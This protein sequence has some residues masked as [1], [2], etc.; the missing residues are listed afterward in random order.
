MSTVYTFIHLYL[1]RYLFVFFFASAAVPSTAQVKIMCL[2][3][4]ITQGNTENPGYRY[5]LWQKLIDAGVDVQ[6]VGSHAVNEGG[7]S[8]VEGTV[9]KGVPYINRNEGHWGWTVDEILSGRDGKGHLSRWLQSYTPDIA[10]IHLGTNDM[11]RQCGTGNTCYQETIDELK[12]VVSQIRAKNPTVAVYLAQ[13]IP[14]YEQKVGPGAAKNIRELNK[15]IPALVKELHT[16]TSPVVLVDQHA[17]FDPTTGVDT[18]D[19]VHPNASG[20][21]KMAQKWFNAIEIPSAPLPTELTSFT[22][23]STEEGYIQLVWETASEKDNAYFEVQQSTDGDTFELAGKVTGAGTTAT[24]QRY[25]FTD[26]TVS[27]R[28][29]Y[30]RL[31]QVN[32]NGTSSLSEVVQVEVPERELALTVF[33]TKSSGH[34]VTLHLLEGQATTEAEVY[35]YTSEGKLVQQPKKLKSRNGVFRTRILTGQLQGAG[36]Y[37]VRVVVASKVYQTEFMIGR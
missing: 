26:S 8:P 6:L 5:R 24:P 7:D 16:A 4:S 20:E 23:R 14:A 10:L 34:S 9:Y 2:G 17:G 21:A 30:Y 22:G 29:V 35:V 15:R 36:L 31:K 1:L 3:N 37:F 27:A 33:P 32:T 12:E 19:G 11:F 18:W 28:S 13:L 25:T